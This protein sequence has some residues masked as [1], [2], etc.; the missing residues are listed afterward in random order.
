MKPSPLWVRLRNLQLFRQL[1]IAIM[2]ELALLTSAAQIIDLGLR[3]ASSMNKLVAKLQHA[4]KAVENA[5]QQIKAIVQICQGIEAKNISQHPHSPLASDLGHCLTN[6]SIPI[7]ELEHIMTQ[8]E[9]KSSD[10][11]FRRV[12]KAICTVKREEEIKNVVKRLEIAKGN[13]TLCL[14]RENL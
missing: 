14:C 11:K 6:C 8:L 2:A 10:T 13:L 4:P 5:Q 3:A 9:R 1:M 12:W 7:R